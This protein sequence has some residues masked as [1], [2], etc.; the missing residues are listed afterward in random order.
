MPVPLETSMISKVLIKKL[1]VQNFLS[2]GA[3]GAEIDLGPLNVIIGQN[4]SGK[5]NLIEVLGLI[6]AT[7]LEKALATRIRSGGGIREW[8]WKGG[9]PATPGEI[10]AIVSPLGGHPQQ[11]WQMPLRY[12]IKL[13]ELGQRFEIVEELIE[14]EKPRNQYDQ[15]PYFYYKYQNGQA[16]INVQKVLEKEG[17]RAQRNLQRDDILPE[18][19]I[20]SQRKDPEQYPEIF[21]LGRQFGEIRIFADWSTGRFTEPRKPQA[22]D[23]TTD[24]LDEDGKNL[25]LVL[26]DLEHRGDTYKIIIDRLRKFYERADGYSVKIEGGTVQLFLREAGVAGPIPATRLSDGTLRY[27]CLL[28]ILCHPS[29]PPLICIEEP[30]MGLHPDILP[31]VA[32]LLKEASSRTQLVVT[33]HSD[34]LISALSD[35]PEAILVC[36]RT[37]EG[38]QISRLN[39]EALK[40]WLEDYSIGE[41]WLKGEIGGTRW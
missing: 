10:S 22:A 40:G 41:L 3:K 35:T 9:Q 32:E 24:F 4:A 13:A 25:G 18:D 14:D 21:Y 12:S 34:I 1:K 15:V 33:T 23:S 20:I 7:A 17:Q 5:S 37:E 11:G 28:S 26:N 36:E 6:H 39:A 29:P 2:F 31:T 8:I 38:T 27:L 30:E 19:S 16:V